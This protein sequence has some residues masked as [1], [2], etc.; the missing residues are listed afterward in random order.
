MKDQDKTKQQL[1]SEVAELR[2]QAGELETSAADRKRAEEL[3][4]ERIE[5][6]KYLDIAGVIIIAINTEGIVTLINKKGCE[7]LG[8]KAK[9]IIGKSWFDN[10][11]PPRISKLVKPVSQ[12]LLSGE[13]EQAEYYENP[14]LTKGGEE[15][16]IAWHNT[17]LT[18]ETGNIIGHL[19]SGEDITEQKEAEEA[20]RKSEERYRDL[21]DNA[22]DLIQSVKP[23]GHFI[24]VNL[25]WRK[26]LGYTRKEI[27]GLS[28][29]DII[30]PDCRAHCMEMWQRVLSGESVS[31]IETV[32][33][34]KGGEKITVEGSASCRFVNGKPVATRGIFRNI[35]ERKKMDEKLKES[36]EKYRAL[37]ENATDFIFQIDKDMTVLSVNKATAD[38]FGQEPEELSGKTLFDLFPREIAAEYVEGL[39]DILQTGKPATIEFEI[40]IREKEMW[41]STSLTPVRG[42]NSK[43]ATVIGVARDV[44]EKKIMDEALQESEEKYRSLIA[45]IP[46]V[47][48]TSDEDFNIVFVGPN[49]DKLTGYTQEEEY[50]EGSWFKWFSRVH[51][52]DREH[53]EK[54]L[55]DLMKESKLYD[56]EYRFKRQDGRWIWIKNRSTGTY[57][58]EGKLYA[59]GLLTDITERKEIEERLK[60][61]EE[62]YRTVFE[63]TGT[64]TAIIEE[65]TTVSLV[66]TQ[67]EKLSGYSKEEV[68]GRM[69]WTKLVSKSDLE[70]MKK[71]HYLRRQNP[72]A[73]PKEYEFQFH[74]KAGNTKDALLTV[75]IIPGTKRSICSMLDITDLKKATEKLRESE[76]R[77]RTL[78]NLGG[79]VGE[80]I[81][82]LQDTGKGNAVHTFVSK[83]WPHITGYSEEE[84]LGMS[85]FDLVHPRYRQA[86]L[87]RHR[88]KMTGETI[89]ELFEMAIIRKDG[90]EVP[91]ELTSA[92]T[93]YREQHANVAF[94]R[95]TTERKQAEERE[96]RLQQELYLSSRL[97]AIGELAAGVAH[98]VNNLL[99]G[100]L[101]YS[102]LLLRKTTDANT[103][104]GL[105]IIN[106]SAQRVARIVQNLL[107]FAR[108]HKPEKALVKINEAVEKALELR[109]YELN[110]GN[111]EVILDLSPQSPQVIG[112]FHQ[113]Q[114]VFLNL[115]LNAEQA[116]SETNR[117]G[118]KG[119]LTIRTR[120]L[121]SRVK[122]SFADNGPG[123]PDEHLDKLFDPF[124]TTRD[125]KGGT[126]LGLSICHGIVTEHE[127]KIYAKSR[128]G[129]GTTFL[130]ELSRAG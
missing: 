88:R 11:L 126:G 63:N 43:V 71:Y 18:D 84:L 60:E 89:A 67:F 10:F 2:R 9:E 83:E 121:K 103:R 90:A 47:I 26:T 15:R 50:R 102:E 92:Y 74:D 86:A 76:E 21:F 33:V 4:K 109:A 78:I 73:V 118:H 28:L 105:K 32:F 111:I 49:V 69:S 25:A 45:N 58:E 48:W 17:T 64:A 35:T 128:M 39:E 107:T 75:D 123:I 62:K 120:Q 55:E 77:Y 34:T 91:I 36:E 96:K 72:N 81:V 129:R 42:Q 13:I 66:N 6:Q 8:Y 100:V 16:I 93:I 65:D 70:R 130:I 61:G 116:M 108:R 56:I 24:Y 1:I 7:V 113:I 110:T 57:Q 14:V 106:E 122:I 82:M 54:A 44:T 12:K 19:S 20:L 85:F 87:H 112:D 31:G 38:L 124:F 29:F 95:E 68:E 94:I 79:A 119:K 97:A 30:H 59:D 27:D 3:Q 125:K 104:K 40:T 114:E 98:E 80:A 23:D 99:T 51:P 46:D 37:V 41:W 5:A 22:N 101:G 52:D 53:A 117:Q 127:G 115:I